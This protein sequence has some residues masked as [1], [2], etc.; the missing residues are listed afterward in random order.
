MIHEVLQF[1]LRIA[2]CFVLHR[3][4]NRDTHR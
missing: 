2:V 3:Y 4:Q 1:A